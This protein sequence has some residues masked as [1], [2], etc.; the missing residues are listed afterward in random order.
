M[1]LNI[2]P[3]CDSPFMLVN[4]LS[5]STELIDTLPIV[6]DTKRLLFMIFLSHKI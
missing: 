6:G 2:M 3:S 4:G 1:I 5:S